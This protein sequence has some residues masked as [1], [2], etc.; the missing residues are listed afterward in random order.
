VESIRP[1][2]EADDAEFRVPANAREVDSFEVD[3]GTAAEHPSGASPRSDAFPLGVGGLAAR[4][5]SHQTVPIYP[6]AAKAAGIDG[7]VVLA[8]RI[9]KSGAVKSLRVLSGPE[10]LRQA[11]RDAVRSWVYRPYLL[12]ETAVEFDTTINVVFTL[13][14]KPG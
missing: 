14:N 13:G 8:A 11:A 10:P 4:L 5:L 3:S 6:P 2:D 7:T 12:N 9:G 1:L